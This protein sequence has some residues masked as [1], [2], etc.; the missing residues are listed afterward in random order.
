MTAEG[1]NTRSV[2]AHTLVMNKTDIAAGWSHPCVAAEL[3]AAAVREK[4]VRRS[5]DTR[6][7]GG[8]GNG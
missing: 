4:R 8:D 1:D 5:E 6:R 3:F 7:R 2:T